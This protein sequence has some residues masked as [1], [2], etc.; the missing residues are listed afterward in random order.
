[1]SYCTVFCLKRVKLEED[2]GFN[3]GYREFAYIA[4]E[5]KQISEALETLLGYINEPRRF[6]VAVGLLWP[7]ASLVRTQNL[8]TFN[9]FHSMPIPNRL[10][11]TCFSPFDIPT[12]KPWINAPDLKAGA[13][14]IRVSIDDT[15]ELKDWITSVVSTPVEVGFLHNYPR[16]VGITREKQ[17]ILLTLNVSE[18]I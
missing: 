11:A 16:V 7:R 18:A 9:P 15:R 12:T 6:Q 3:I 17:T 1:M 13:T 8:G 4:S 5:D 14:K 10:L 2:I